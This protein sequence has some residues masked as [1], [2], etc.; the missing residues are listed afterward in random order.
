[1]AE[2]NIS[3][4]RRS[5]CGDLTSCFDFTSPNPTIPALPDTASLRRKPTKSILTCLPHRHPR[6]SRNFRNKNR[7][8]PK[9]GRFRINPS[10]TSRSGRSLCTSP[11][12]TPVQRPFLSLC[13]PTP[14]REC[15][16]QEHRCRCQKRDRWFDPSDASTSS[17]DVWVHGPNGFLA[18][19]AGDMQSNEVGV[20]ATVS[21]VGAATHPSLRLTVSNSGS[22]EATVR[23]TD[24]QGQV[25][26]LQISP[27]GGTEQPDTTRSAKPTAGRVDVDP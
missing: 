5:I 18:H 13:P 7:V 21:L 3:D 12:P 8:T 1:M 25:Q 9:Q 17:Y 6:G 19:A 2:P 16:C 24:R 22:S 26:V 4:W 10:P 27:G 11:W 23:V 15:Q 20:E 14:T